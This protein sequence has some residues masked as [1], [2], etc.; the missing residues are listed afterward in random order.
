MSS[1]LFVVQWPLILLIQEFREWEICTDELTQQEQGRA[2]LL[3]WDS[4]FSL[5]GFR[6][7]ALSGL[8]FPLP[9]IS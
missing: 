9:K 4:P 6:A 3:S 2:L 1:A 8:G 5:E 7:P